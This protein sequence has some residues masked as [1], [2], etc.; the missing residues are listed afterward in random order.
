MRRASM[1]WLTRFLPSLVPGLGALVN[2]WVLLAL[3]GALVGSFLYGLHIGN[4]RLESYQLAVRAVGQAQEERTA[5]NIK[6]DK[7]NKE[8]TDRAHKTKLAAANRFANALADQLRKAP[9]GGFVP[10]A[11]AGAPSPDRACFDRSQLDG[12]LRNFAADTA[13]LIAEGDRAIIGL[14]ASKNWITNQRK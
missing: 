12:A 5:A 11:P 13:G 9:S 8:A 4:S 7:A 3:L 10:A 6:T 14:D 1:N 2:P